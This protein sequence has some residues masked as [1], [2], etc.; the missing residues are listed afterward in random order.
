MT[1]RDLEIERKLGDIKDKLDTLLIE[2]RKTDNTNTNIDS[3]LE[4][5]KAKFA[6]YKN[7]EKDIL[8]SDRNVEEKYELLQQEQAKVGSEITNIVKRKEAL[9]IKI[10]MITKQL[11]HIEAEEN[12]INQKK[13]TI[14]EECSKIKEELED[15]FISISSITTNS[16]EDFMDPRLVNLLHMRNIDTIAGRQGSSL[17]NSLTLF[18]YNWRK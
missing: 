18:Q 11:K 1:K 13:D 4:I 16:S 5:F 7:D 12:I 6:A 9:E 8:E 10:E 2:K 14:E 15:L 17:N 3:R